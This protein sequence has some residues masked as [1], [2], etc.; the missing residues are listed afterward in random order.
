MMSPVE[1][2]NLIDLTDFDVE[3]TPQDEV[4]VVAIRAYADNAD[5]VTLT[6]DE[7][8]GSVSIVWNGLEEERLRL[9]RESA[10]RVTVG[11]RA[12]IIDF[13][14]W[15]TADGLQGKLFISVGRTVTVSDTILRV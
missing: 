3:V 14:V 9:F 13:S 6:W 11:Q 1:V 5:T 12:G 4:G 10:S 8:A 2:P 7:I 15:M